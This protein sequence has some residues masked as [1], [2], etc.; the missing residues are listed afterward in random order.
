MKLKSL[1]S[2]RSLPFD[3]EEWK[4]Q[5]FPQRVKMICQAWAVQGYGAPPSVYLFYLLKIG[6]YIG[7]WLW[8]CSFSTDLGPPSDLGKWW[9]HPDAILK[10]IIWSMMFEGMGL[11]SGSGPLTGRYLPPFGGFL[12][13]LRPGTLK[14]PT[15]A[16]IPLLGRDQRSWLDVL[17]YAAHLFFLLRLLIAPEITPEI[18][19]PT[20]ILLPVLGLSDRS[21][22]LS[23]RA[24]H[25][26]IALICVMFPDETLGGLKFVWIGIWVWAA[27]SKLNLHFPS[28]VGV[29]ISNSPVLGFLFLRKM[30]YRSYPDDLRPGNLAKFMAHGGTVVEYLFPMILLFGPG[31][32]VWIGL[33]VM[34]GF[35]LFITSNVPMGVPIEWNFMMVYGGFAL[36]GGHPEANP[37]ALHSPLLIGLL[38][39]SLFVLP[40]LG[41][42]FPKYFSF[43][44][45][46]RYYAGNWAYSVWLFKG[47]AEEKLDEQ[48]NKVSPTVLKQLALF[49]DPSTAESIVSRVVAFRHMHLHGRALHDLVPRAVDH[50]DQYTWRDGELVAGVVLGWNFGDAHL[51][52]EAL[53]AAV[54]KRCNYAEG[55][56]R[57]I[58]V[59]SQ[60]F[61]GKEM[62]WRI[63][64]AKTGRIAEG[65]VKVRELA[66]R[67]PWPTVQTSAPGPQ[68]AK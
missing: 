62:Q 68:S 21:I 67:M 15:F 55:E 11:A 44:L 38:A 22:F 9:F 14:I 28:V 5:P 29:M 52:S 2:P 1:L 59:E 43:L 37:F 4:T 17:L 47:K 46:M 56:L 16:W 64:D 54:Q 50:I 33:L 66:G 41:N 31:D 20:L 32:W 12:Y 51:S 60:P 57:C 35:H 39:T 40:V 53:L 45:S 3:F 8:F 48:I 61:F 49:Y 27:T 7:L 34:F 23:A 13:F 24:E 36:F 26:L 19:F 58:F 30:I 6:I 18:V 42:L 63:H 65:K 25:Y 10:G